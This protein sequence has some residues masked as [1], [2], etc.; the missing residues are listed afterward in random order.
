MS[1]KCLYK[2][3]KGDVRVIDGNHV[4][5]L[6][7]KTLRGA[8][9]GEYFY[10]DEKARERL[11]VCNDYVEGE[12]SV[13]CASARNGVVG[14]EFVPIRMK[15][16]RVAGSMFV[17]DFDIGDVGG[18]EIRECKAKSED[19]VFP[20]KVY[21]VVGEDLNGAG[22]FVRMFITREDAEKYC[23]GYRIRKWLKMNDM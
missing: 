11:V 18:V 14:L 1:N 21:E 17:S 7:N 10:A 4:L 5:Y 20:K 13:K 9:S 2:P 6:R 3:H 19:E 22:K 16:W 15:V 8:F 23:R 12:K